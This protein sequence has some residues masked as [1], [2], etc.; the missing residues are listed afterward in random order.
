MTIDIN[1]TNRVAHGK[2]RESTFGVIPTS[3]AIKAIRVTSSSL[4]AKPTTIVSDEI[5][6]DRQVTDLNLVGT[7]ADGDVGAELS[8]LAQ[9]DDFEEVLQSAWVSNPN[10]VNIAADTQISALTAT[11]ATVA[12]GGAAFLAGMIA[13]LSGFTTAGNNKA[14]VVA[15]S[16]ATT[17]VFPSST[18]TEEAGAIPVGASLR[19][20]GV[21][22]AASDIVA[23]AGP[24]GL[25]S[26]LLDF[27]TLGLVAG[28][29]IKVGG[30]AAGAK[31]ATAA[32]NDWCRIL[33]IAADAMLFDRVPASWGADVGTGK[34][35]SIFF[36]DYL[37]N[38]STLL[39][40]TFERQY[41]DQSPVSYEYLTGMCLDKVALTVSSQ[42]IM[43]MVKSYIGETGT[44]STSRASGASDVAAPVNQILNAS[45]NVGRLGVNGATVTG[46]NYVMEATID[47]ANNLR[48][49]NAV[50]NLGAIGMGNGEFTL[51]GSLNTYFGDL[52]YY[53]LLLANS[54]S[55]FDFRVGRAD[56]NKEAYLFDMPRMKFSSGAPTVPGKNQNVMLPLAFQ[57]LRDPTLG[58][59]IH[60]QRHWYLE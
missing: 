57:A 12:A 22:G 53:N 39:S 48:P 24:N 1:S 9:D 30:A 10:I 21:Q 38:G 40:S 26:T 29:W 20:V 28:Q 4:S 58:Y 52:T 44:I 6:S 15:S 34:T 8:F 54:A 49:L 32:N 31:F 5:R 16:T 60:M 25:S 18:F 55:S 46:P 33:S 23:T 19:A 13:L 37:R 43:T 2:V 41:L 17:V 14:A 59:T 27:T 11:T 51:T 3:P 7:Q 35:I 50:G 45:A 42:K 36:G 56:G 47:I